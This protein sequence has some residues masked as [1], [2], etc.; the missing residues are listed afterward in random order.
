[1]T[2]RYTAGANADQLHLVAFYEARQP[3]LGSDFDAEVGAAIARILAFPHAGAAVTGAPRGR[4]IRERSP[5]GSRSSSPTR[6]T[7]RWP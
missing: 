1:M 3:G 7:G 4:E 6:W 2:H 5:G